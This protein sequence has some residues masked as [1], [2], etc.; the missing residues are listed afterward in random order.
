MRG[1]EGEEE[2]NGDLFVHH[3]QAAESQDEYPSQDTAIEAK[4]I[5]S[6]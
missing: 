4:T 5:R 1:G 2:A 3:C 6:S